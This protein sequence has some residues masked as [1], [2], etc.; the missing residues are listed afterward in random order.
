MPRPTVAEIDLAALRHNYKKV[1]EL[2]GSG[3]KV[4][5]IVKANAYGHGAV[6]VARELEQCGVDFLGVAL[7]EEA[8][9]LRNAGIETP[10]VV[11]GGVYNSQCEDVFTYRIIP[12]LFD[13]ETALRLDAL[14][15]QNSLSLKVHIKLDTGM[16]R[17]G[18]LS[19]DVDSFFDQL[20]KCKNLVVDGLLTHLAVADTASA[21]TDSFTVGQLSSFRE[22]AARIRDKGF[23]PSYLHL[24]NSAALIRQLEPCFNLARPGLMLYGISPSQELAIDLKP[25][26]TLKTEIAALKKVPAGCSISYRRTFITSRESLIATLPAGYADGYSRQ[27]SNRASVLIR[28][29]RAPVAGMVCMDM[30]MVDV[31]DIPDVQVHD[32]AVLLGS[33]GGQS[34]DSRELAEIARSIPYEVLCNISSRVPRK[35]LIR[36]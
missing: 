23:S 29:Q 3:S 25:V 1:G 18:I 22:L 4:L 27:F 13:I 10:L 6:A 5:A 8:V 11:L 7:C 31:T 28:G 16:G 21:A 35:Y 2:A 15:A 9:E 26:M 33:Q 34:I 30:V 12:V 19:R 14:A 20:I 32:E 36:R 17:I 24:A